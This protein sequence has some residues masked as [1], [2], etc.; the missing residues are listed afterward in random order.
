MVIWFWCIHENEG[1]VNF[2]GVSERDDFW[3]LGKLSGC[4]L[5][6]KGLMRVDIFNG[7]M[8]E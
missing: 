6:K 4:G 5:C 2:G 8:V 3:L 1:W 7:S